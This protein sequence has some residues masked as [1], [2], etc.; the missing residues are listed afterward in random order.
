MTVPPESRDAPFC[1][2]RC[3]MADLGA[4]LTESYR[5]PAEPD[6]DDDGE[7]RPAHGTMPPPDGDQ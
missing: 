5:I 4:W 2:P 6:D 3:R 1:S 7:S